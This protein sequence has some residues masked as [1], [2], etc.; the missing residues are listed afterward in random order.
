[1]YR[2]LILDSILV[3]DKEGR[4]RRIYCP[5][6]VKAIKRSKSIE[7]GR[8]YKVNAVKWIRGEAVYL[9]SIDGNDFY[10]FNFVIVLD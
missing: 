1:M 10:Y 2:I 7:E 6:S 9:Y 4:L 5:F 3:I 8:F